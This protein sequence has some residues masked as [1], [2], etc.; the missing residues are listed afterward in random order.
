[1]T[2]GGP[3]GVNCSNGNEIYAFHSGGANVTMGD[4]SCRFLREGINIG[5]LAAMVTKAN[6]EVYND[7]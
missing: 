2:S 5:T 1:M 3:C 4:G 7:N 6:G